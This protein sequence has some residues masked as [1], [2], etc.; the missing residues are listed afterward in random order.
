MVHV[1]PPTI[2]NVA[3]LVPPVVQTEGVL[4]EK[5]TGRPEVAVALNVNG[6]TPKVTGLGVP[7][8]IV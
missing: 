3:P 6:A 8:E 4:E 7:K 1:P 2:V 5:L